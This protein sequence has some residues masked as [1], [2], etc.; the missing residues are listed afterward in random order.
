[1]L[2]RVVGLEPTRCCQQEILSL[3][4]LPFRHTRIIV[5]YHISFD[6]SSILQ[7]MRGLL[8]GNPLSVILLSV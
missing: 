6:L 1:M 3:P 7:K 2:V 8:S 5:L 4:R